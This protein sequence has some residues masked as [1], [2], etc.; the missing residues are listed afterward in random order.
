MKK[1]R[2]WRNIVQKGQFQKYLM[3]LSNNRTLWRH[4]RFIRPIN[5]R[6]AK[7]PVEPKEKTCMVRQPRRVKKVGKDE[8]KDR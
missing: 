7:T 5:Y 2:S 8:T 6:A 1:P 3:K 4:R